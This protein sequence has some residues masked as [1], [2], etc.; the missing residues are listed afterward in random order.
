VEELAE[1]MNIRIKEKGLIVMVRMAN[2]LNLHF[3]HF[4]NQITI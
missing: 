3:S 2:A 1:E 4:P